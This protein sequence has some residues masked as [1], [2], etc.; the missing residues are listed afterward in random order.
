M[1][2]CNEA[3]ALEAEAILKDKGESIPTSQF[4]SARSLQV[5]TIAWGKIRQDQAKYE[6]STPFFE[7]AD[8]FGK[9]NVK[10]NI[11]KF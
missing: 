2:E 8:M 3:V 4:K 1:P 9:Q 7:V 10:N 5:F 11:G 6:R